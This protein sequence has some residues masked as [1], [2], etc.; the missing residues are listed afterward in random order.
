MDVPQRE[1]RESQPRLPP[2]HS[3]S[4]KAGLKDEVTSETFL[5]SQFK[6]AP[7]RNFSL[8]NL[9][10]MLP[11]H[12]SILFQKKFDLKNWNNFLVKR[13]IPYGRKNSSISGPWFD[14]PSLSDRF[15]VEGG[16]NYSASASSSTAS[17]ATSS[18][19][20]LPRSQRERHPASEWTSFLKVL[21]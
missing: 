15:I 10:F 7:I 12:S 16:Y 8:W 14:W 5:H 1:F 6:R 21:K 9:T 4:D 11:S 2:T 13:Y 3:F 18:L 17:S 19:H 20:L